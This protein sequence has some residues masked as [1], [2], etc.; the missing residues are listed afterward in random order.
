MSVGFDV[1]ILLYCQPFPSQ[2]TV[3]VL[4]ST[5]KPPTMMSPPQPI[6]TLPFGMVNFT[7]FLSLL[8]WLLLQLP[9]PMDWPF[10]LKISVL[11]VMVTSWFM[12]D[13]V[14]TT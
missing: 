1:S 3:P 13:A 14:T 5:G 9:A 4:E 10:R 11:A 12:V 7:V 8:S 6:I 2:S